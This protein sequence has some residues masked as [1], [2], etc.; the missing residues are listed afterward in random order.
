MLEASFW[1]DKRNDGCKPRTIWKTSW[2]KLGTNLLLFSFSFVFHFF[3]LLFLFFFS[4]L[5][6]RWLTLMGRMT[7]I[8]MYR[9]NAYL[10][11]CH[12][13]EENCLMASV[14]CKKALFLSFFNQENLPIFLKDEKSGGRESVFPFLLFYIC[15]LMQ[16]V[17]PKERANDWYYKAAASHFGN[18]KSF[19][20]LLSMGFFRS[21]SH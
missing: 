20:N 17:C 3:P 15:T 8:R 5:S 18:L 11:Q 13:G 2:Y 7:M 16:W 10:R 1:C 9:C 14:T 12:Q 19:S 21:A 4:L 6:K